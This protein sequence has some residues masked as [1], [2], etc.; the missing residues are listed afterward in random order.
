[1]KYSLTLKIKWGIVAIWDFFV[2]L[3]LLIGVTR[4]LGLM[5]MPKKAK[6]LLIFSEKQMGFL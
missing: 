5:L 6:G 3:L 4:K 1:V 2:S